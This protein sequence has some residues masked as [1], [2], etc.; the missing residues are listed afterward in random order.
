MISKKELE[1]YAKTRNMKNLGH[2]EKDYFQNIVLFIIYQEFGNEIV[3]KGGTALSKCFGLNRFSEDLDFTCNKEID[4]KNIEKGLKRFKI[5]F[6]TE[7]IEF[8]KS[9]SYIIR[10]KGPL[11]NGSKTSACKIL[12]DFSFR[13]FVFIPPIIKTIGRFIDEIPSFDVYVMN[14]EEILAEKIRAIISRNKARDVYDLLFL[15][16]SN[17]TSKEELVNKKL[18]YYKKKYNK[19]E[20]LEKLEE[21]REIW[22][23][24]IQKLVSSVTSFEEVFKKIKESLNRVLIKG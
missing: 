1:E 16:E 14:P 22:N 19:K 2:A 23:S 24:E 10:L 11:Y 15:I 20:F 5:D 17:I 18:D 9:K 3:F 21:K 7:K 13:E 8:E 4:F 12:L 6:E